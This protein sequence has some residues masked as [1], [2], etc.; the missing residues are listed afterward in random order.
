MEFISSKNVAFL[1]NIIRMGQKDIAWSQGSHWE[2]LRK[3][4]VIATRF[5]IFYNV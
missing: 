4:G 2:V 1:G 3:V 5:V